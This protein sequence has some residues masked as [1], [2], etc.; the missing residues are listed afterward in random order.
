MPGTGDGL[1]VLSAMRHANPKVV[2]MIL[3]VS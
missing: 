3:S 1:T 2:T